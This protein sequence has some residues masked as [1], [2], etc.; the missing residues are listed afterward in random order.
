MRQMHRCAAGHE[1]FALFA[2]GLLAAASTLPAQQ[3]ATASSDSLLR[4]TP[5]SPAASVAERI[6]AAA[7]PRPGERI[8]GRADVPGERT[9]TVIL[10]REGSPAGMD[11][12]VWPVQLRWV[13]VAHDASQSFVADLYGRASDRGRLYLDGVVTEGPRTGSAVH[14]ETDGDLGRGASITITPMKRK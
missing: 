12:A 3:L 13:V 6:A 8:Y 1:L 5:A 10:V 2:A 11:E 14:I 7:V 9:V 4:T